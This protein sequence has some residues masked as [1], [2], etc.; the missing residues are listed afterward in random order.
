MSPKVR[1]AAFAS[2]FAIFAG[3]TAARAHDLFFRAPRYVLAPGEGVVVDVLSGSFSRSENAISR[4]RLAELVLAGPGGRHKVP[5]S[6]WTETDPKSTLPLA[7][8]GDGT[9]VLGAAVRPRLLT[10]PGKEF[11]AYL[12]EEGQDDILA[13]RIA[14]KR[15]GEP[16]RERYSKYLKAVFQV[17][18]ADDAAPAVLGHAAEIIPDRNPYRL[19]P[20]DPLTVRCLVDGQPWARKVVLAGGRRGT[21]DQRLPQQRLVTN[22]DG[23]ATLRIVEAGIWYVKLVAIREITDPEANYESKWATLTFAVGPGR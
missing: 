2:A 13:A 6:D 17:G 7:F 22:D 12:K 8:E 9:Y 18:A 11:A 21:T 16:S 4:D 3:V 1:V 20:G 23:R 15:S 14:Q 19:R 10:L 5:L